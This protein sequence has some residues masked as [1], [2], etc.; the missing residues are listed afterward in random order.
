M[1]LVEFHW[2]AEAELISAAQ[3]YEEH[4]ENLGFDFVTAVQRS[5]QRLLDFPDQKT[6]QYPR[7]LDAAVMSRRPSTEGGRCA[8]RRRA[9][10][11]LGRRALQPPRV[12]PGRS[13]MIR[14][15]P[16][17]QVSDRARACLVG[18]LR[19]AGAAIALF[20]ATAAEAAE[21]TVDTFQLRGELAFPTY[22][23]GA[24]GFD[25]PFAV[26]LQTLLATNQDNSC[27]NG[28]NS[29]PSTGTSECGDL[30][31]APIDVEEE[32]AGFLENDHIEYQARLLTTGTW[33]FL[34]G[35]VL[36]APPAATT[37]ANMNVSFGHRE[38]FDVTSPASGP[39]PFRLR[40]REGEVVPAGPFFCPGIWRPFVGRNRSLRVRTQGSVQSLVDAVL[41]GPLGVPPD[42]TTVETLS[43]PA[44]ERVIQEWDFEFEV[45]ANTVLFVD[46]LYDQVGGTFQAPVTDPISGQPCPLTVVA[47]GSFAP[48]GGIQLQ[49]TPGPDLSAVPR[50]G[51]VYEPV[52][53][54]GA[55]ASAA[56]AL[57]ALEWWRRRSR[58]R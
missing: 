37:F 11:R 16:E 9:L 57:A 41:G 56:A 19:T 6:Q 43:D 15:Q 38:V 52:P 33:E 22:T 29:N 13:R 7:S 20:A 46:V 50:S 40:L 1:R 30:V 12:T 21:C 55:L 10:P 17:V 24:I 25:Q 42:H 28:C 35:V 48:Y 36:H 34:P 4:A 5:Y 2:E 8:R 32:V 39:Q 3:Y 47:G 49:V 18:G 58:A 44:Y 26:V 23:G 53:E 54:P 51:L 31:T 45:P 14:T 27:N